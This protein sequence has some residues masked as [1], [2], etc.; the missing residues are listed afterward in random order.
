[1]ARPANISGIP[2]PGKTRK[3]NPKISKVKP[4]VAVTNQRSGWGNKSQY[5]LILFI[6]APSSR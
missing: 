3:I 6:A 1:M 2:G 4:T 5:L